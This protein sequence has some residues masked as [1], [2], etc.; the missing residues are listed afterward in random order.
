MSQ[1]SFVQIGVAVLILTFLSRWLWD[2]NRAR[3]EEAEQHE[4]KANPP[5]H[6]TYATKTEHV[7]LKERV[8]A[9]EEKVDENFRVLDS[10]RSDDVAALHDKLE[11]ITRDLNHRVDAVPERTIKL[12]R[13]TQQLHT[14]R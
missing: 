4:P 2:Y 8:Q 1:P 12:L 13:E 11:Q 9:V 6:A 3:R 7:E 14:A 5:L 10:K